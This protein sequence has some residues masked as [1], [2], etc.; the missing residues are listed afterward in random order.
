[1]A[2]IKHRVGVR[3]SIEEIFAALTEP[4]DLA[5]WW[6]TS[7]S[8]AP[9]VGKTLEL[10]FGELVTLSF[11]VRELQTDALVELECSSGPFPWL[12]S[13]LRFLLEVADNQIFVTMTH[14]NEDAES[15]SFLYFN[16][17]WPIYLLSLRDYIET[18]RGRPFPGDTK[19]HHGD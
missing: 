14:S 5:G 18:G 16:T 9:E 7:A 10:T 19:I 15:D 1:M 12:G 6:A 3:G 13:R 11:L 2:E 8:G 17:K 4:D